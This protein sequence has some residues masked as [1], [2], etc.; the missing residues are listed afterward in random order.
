M[1]K[2]AS[3]PIV[4]FAMWE[5]IKIILFKSA[6]FIQSNFRPT[7]FL[8]NPLIFLSP[9]IFFQFAFGQFP[10]VVKGGA[11]I[12]Q[13]CLP[14]GGGIHSL[15]MILPA[16]RVFLKC[17]EAKNKSIHFIGH[18]KIHANPP[19]IFW[20][21]FPFIFSVTNCGQMGFGYGSPWWCSPP[22]PPSTHRSANPLIR[23]FPGEWPCPKQPSQPPC[24][25]NYLAIQFNSNKMAL[26]Q[27]WIY[28]IYRSILWKWTF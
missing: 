24:H 23:P 27:K 18:P 14:V 8:F 15:E 3:M 12:N 20:L 1:P 21:K 11:E 2:A 7:P 6:E 16:L 4:P 26:F 9:L 17:P 13:N 10:M 22:S 28:Q 5:F 19:F 25:F